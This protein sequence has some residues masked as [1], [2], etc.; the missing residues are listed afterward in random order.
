M[1]ANFVPSSGDAVADIKS[2]GQRN[3]NVKLVKPYMGMLLDQNVTILEVKP[4]GATF[5]GSNLRMCAVLGGRIYLH[6]RAFPKP[7]VAQVL[8]VNVAKGM[9]ILSDF[10]YSDTDWEERKFER[11]RP[12]NP[13]YVSLRWKRKS[14]RACLVDISAHGIGL[15]VYKLGER[16]LNIQ[17]GS[18]VYLDFELP[19]DYRWTDLKGKVVNL[20]KANGSL[21]RLGLRIYSNAMEAHCLERYIIH[22]KGEIWEELNQAYFKARRPHGVECSYF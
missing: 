21:A 19:A 3:E 11:V 18:R 2:L 7:V 15:V 13:T 12:K 16:G 4:E 5:Q 17:A 8:D 10:A 14:L 20:Q 6:S 1:S 22:R 9:F